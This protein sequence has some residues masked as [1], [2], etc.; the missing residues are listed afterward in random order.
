MKKACLMA[1]LAFLAQFASFG[2]PIFDGFLDPPRSSAPE[3]WWHWMNGNVTKEGITA[4]LEA[5]AWAGL[6]G[7]HMFDVDCDIPAGPVAFGGERW[8]EMVEHAHREAQRLGL[9]LTLHNCSGF[10]SSGGPWVTPADSMKKVVVSELRV[11]GPK[12]GEFVLPRP[13]TIEGFYRDIR[14][15]AV[16]ASQGELFPETEGEPKTKEQVL[17]QLYVKTVEFG[18]P[19]AASQ[20][21]LR[22][23]G[24]RSSWTGLKC[25]VTVKASDDGERF[26]TVLD[27]PDYSLRVGRQSE[28]ETRYIDFPREVSARRY[29]IFVDFKGLEKSGFR[30]C[31]AKIGRA[32]RVPFTAIAANALYART[33]N[34]E[35]APLDD[36][37]CA[38]EKFKVMDLTP[39]LNGD[40]I[41]CSIP[42]GTWQ[43]FRIGYTSTGVR[44]HPATAQGLGLEV[45]KF[46]APAV[47]R[48]FDGYLGPLSARLGIGKGGDAPR[49]G[50][51]AAL[52]D[53]YEVGCQNWT[54]GFEGEFKRRCGYDIGPY[55]L[56]FA[57]KL[58][59]SPAETSAFLIDFRRVAS[60]LFCENYAGV[61][62][63]K[64]NEA[65]LSLM[66]EPYGSFPA[67]DQLYG[68]N[69]DD[70]MWEFWCA[71]PT[72]EPMFN[73]ALN[74]YPVASVAHVLG[75]RRVSA[76]SFTS[77]AA[78]RGWTQDFWS[79][80]GR[81]DEAYAAGVNN[82]V[83]HRWAHQPWTN[84]PRL[85][86]MTMGPW[87]TCFER[88]QT[89]WPFVRPWIRYQTRCQH[90]LQEGRPVKDILFFSGS[91]QPNAGGWN[92]MVGQASGDDPLI[93]L[94]LN[95]GINSLSGSMLRRLAV[96][97]GRL[98]AP[99]GVSYSVL[100]HNPA[101][102]CSVGDKRLIDE[103]RSQGVK[104][105]DDFPTR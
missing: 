65:G 74:V 40:T 20:L 68:A 75:N 41:K 59:N 37:R 17:G 97:D 53:S 38:I 60:E 3:V 34:G 52:I 89:W 44:N 46:S 87:G 85:P 54:D 49:T 62:R 50:V 31:E 78:V 103:W 8:L 14:V 86:G 6:S 58:V 23:E 5:M 39:F 21:Q 63:R 72:K 26:E 15:L 16:P 92:S 32:F 35:L 2:D 94:Q 93:N 4:D 83:Y 82:V 101:Q 48:F 57:G 45:D 19:R 27:I 36:E 13:R 91:S 22:V 7:A 67:D 70:V 100:I 43:I 98:V 80:K 77:S 10:S 66:A 47:E 11:K 69:C 79:Y 64:C 95:Y 81:G 99:S 88:T 42:E 96:K 84:P 1:A 71:A 29:R 55:L 102:S 33:G 28:L 51:V 9:R 90:L 25:R 24:A 18:E 12:L 73:D 76:E 56:F 30:V 61:M 104:I 105:V